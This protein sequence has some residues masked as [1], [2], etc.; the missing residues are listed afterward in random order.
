MLRDAV[1]GMGGVRLRVFDYIIGGK[2]EL[3]VQIGQIRK[4]GVAV[5]LRTVAHFGAQIGEL[6]GFRL[7]IRL[8]YC[9]RRMQ[10]TQLIDD[11]PCRETQDSFEHRHDRSPATGVETKATAHSLRADGGLATLRTA[12]IAL[13]A[14]CATL[15][16]PAAVTAVQPRPGRRAVPDDPVAAHPGHV[17]HG[18]DALQPSVQIA[19]VFNPQVQFPNGR[20]RADRVRGHSDHRCFRGTHEIGP[21][22]GAP[23]EGLEF[24]LRGQGGL[25]KPVVDGARALERGLVIFGKFQSRVLRRGGTRPGRERDHDDGYKDDATQSPVELHVAPP[26]CAVFIQE[27]AG[28]MFLQDGGENAAH[29]E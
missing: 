26:L 10:S 15:Q 18:Q 4:L 23:I 14:D 27:E 22:S 20:K 5:H 1:V 25:K 19:V 24:P 3:A 21:K 13:L 6:H 29:A 17:V 2:V 8:I 28:E 9:Q 7:E 11:A 16:G 12:V